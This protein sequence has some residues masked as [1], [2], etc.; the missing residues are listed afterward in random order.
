MT[1]QE[2]LKSFLL[3]KTNLVLVGL[4]IAVTLALAIFA[5]KIL[6]K[7][8]VQKLTLQDVDLN[9]DPE[10]P[11]A[12]LE[13]RNDGNAINLIVKRI[14]SYE[15]F[16]YQLV[17]ESEGVERGAGDPNT[18]I[19]LNDK[20]SEYKQEIL[21]GTCSQGYT[22]GGAHCVFDKGVENGT[23]TLRFKK[24]NLAYKMLMTWHLQKPDV[25]LGIITSGDTHFSYKTDATR[26]ELSNSGFSV[27]ND[28]S[29][30]PKMVE[31][32]QFI[33]K[34]YS[35]SVPTAKQ[36]PKG[37]LSIEI[38]DQ[39]SPDSQI[40][41][42]NESKNSWQLLETKISGSVLNA[43]ATSNGIFAIVNSSK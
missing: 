26:Q 30:A 6:I 15:A 43:N 36:F 38:A 8:D 29:G 4:L 42:F 41:W 40:A 16:S 24:G 14:S 20:K 33:G 3:N 37:A 9:F 39:A 12:V 17:Y 34:V 1:A 21:F 27:V 35:F 28:L 18:Y 31:G 19:K 11:F 7:S 23:L 25:A 22:S 5:P 32:K 10:G 13:P 2:K